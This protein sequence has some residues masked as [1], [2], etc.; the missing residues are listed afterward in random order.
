[1]VTHLAGKLILKF[2]LL[3]SFRKFL[4]V[5]LLLATPPVILEYVDPFGDPKVPVINPSPEK[6]PDSIGD[7]NGPYTD[8]PR[9]MSEL[10]E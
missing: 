7:H 2:A 6:A 8:D 1:M 9:H 3:S 5:L 10:S 4:S